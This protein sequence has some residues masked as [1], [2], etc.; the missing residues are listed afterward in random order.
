MPLTRKVT[1]RAILQK[2][3]RVQIPKL[4]IKEFKLEPSQLLKVN[5]SVSNNF[6]GRQS[7]YAKMEKAGRI[8]IQ[9]AT[10]SV[11][12]DERAS[13]PGCI[14]EVTLEPT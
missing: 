14:V 5:F 10:L 4:I 3:E 11:W 12:E 6:K 2:S 13:L 7:F 9:K 1:F 8:Y